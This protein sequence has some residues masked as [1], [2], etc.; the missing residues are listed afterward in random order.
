L[1]AA[2]SELNA[3]K[4]VLD[5]LQK[6]PHELPPSSPDRT[7][8]TELEELKR[9]NA[10]LHQQ[11]WDTEKNWDDVLHRFD[12][13]RTDSECVTVTLQKELQQTLHQLD[14][15]RT[16]FYRVQT[17]HHNYERSLTPPNSR[18][19]SYDGSPMK[20]CEFESSSPHQRVNFP[21]S[22]FCQSIKDHDDKVAN[23][24]GCVQD[25]EH[26]SKMQEAATQ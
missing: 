25:S 11:L 23:S 7:T 2:N 20:L 26:N 15:Y 10:T 22:G 9:A 4:S 16:D 18:G 24:D 13:D 21:D 19:N 5:E 3:A 1:D 14:H 17:R 8:V 12:R 6:L